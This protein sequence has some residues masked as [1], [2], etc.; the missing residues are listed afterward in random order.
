MKKQREHIY[1]P[2]EREHYECQVCNIGDY[3]KIKYDADWASEKGNLISLISTDYLVLTDKGVCR[4]KRLHYRL[5]IEGG[6]VFSSAKEFE[7][8]KRYK[9]RRKLN[10]GVPV[11][12]YFPNGVVLHTMI[13]SI[14]KT[15]D[16]TVEYNVL[17][18]ENV[19]KRLRDEI[20]SKYRDNPKWKN[21]FR[22]KYVMVLP[23]TIIRCE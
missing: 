9:N 13:T 22:S 5:N 23:H 17:E 3:V 15:Q 16:N 21:V 12:V 2:F 4:S 19:T 20:L 10:L 14:S 7:V 1:I 18:D 8:V 6:C 11:K